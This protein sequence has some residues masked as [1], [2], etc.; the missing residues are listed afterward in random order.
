MRTILELLLVGFLLV[1]LGRE[2]RENVQCKDDLAAT[3]VA[4][5]FSRHPRK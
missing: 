5:S 2:V 3:L 4:E 1:L